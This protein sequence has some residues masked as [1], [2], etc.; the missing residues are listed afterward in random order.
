MLRSRVEGLKV[1]WQTLRGE[2]LAFD[3]QGPFL[4]NGEEQ[5]LSGFKHFENPYTTVDFPCEQMEIKT[6]EYVLRLDFSS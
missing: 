2:K 1:E 5:A 4:R 3:W 6:E